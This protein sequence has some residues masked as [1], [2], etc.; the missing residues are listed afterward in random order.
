MDFV[1]RRFVGGSLIGGIAETQEMLD[2]CGKHNITCMTEKIPISYVNTAM[3]RLIKNDVKYRFVIDIGN[4][5]TDKNA[6]ENPPTDKNGTENT[7]TDE[8]DSAEC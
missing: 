8:K 6:I 1:G 4:T 5:L 2:F 7:T 3:E